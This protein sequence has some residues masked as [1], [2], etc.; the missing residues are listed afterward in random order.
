MPVQAE[1]QGYGHFTAFPSGQVVARFADRTLLT[2]SPCAGT[3]ASSASPSASPNPSSTS[4]GTSPHLPL[5]PA[6]PSSSDLSQW[7]C[8]LRLRDGEELV[9]PVERPAGV[10]GYVSA[11]L[12]FLAWARMTPTERLE[13]ALREGTA[14]PKPENTALGRN[15]QQMK[16]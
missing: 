5:S 16:I 2:L 11:A 15:P 12:D 9:V 1:L 10:E 6:G 4:T 13:Q 8:R 3:S 14:E 7:E